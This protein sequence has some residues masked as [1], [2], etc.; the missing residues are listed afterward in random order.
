MNIFMLLI[1]FFVISFINYL[2]GGQKEENKEP[3]RKGQNQHEHD[4]TS[5]QTQPS[6]E[7]RI[8]TVNKSN[9]QEQREQQMDQLMDQLDI[10]LDEEDQKE[11]TAQQSRMMNKEIHQTEHDESAKEKQVMKKRLRKKLNR[12]GLIDSVIMAEVLGRPRALSPYRNR[13][14]RVRK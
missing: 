4:Y 2:L 11:N 13:L 9:V 14:M 8:N 6:K 1:L 5:S 10:S 3:V 7:N 12:D